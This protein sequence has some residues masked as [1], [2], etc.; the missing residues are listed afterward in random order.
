MTRRGRTS[1]RRARGRARPR[2]WRCVDAAS[3][4]L[5]GRR[6]LPAGAAR[7]GLPVPRRSSL[8]CTTTAASAPTGTRWSSRPR[9]IA[10]Q[11]RV[12]RS[13]RRRHRRRRRGAK[14]T[15]SPTILED[16]L[17]P[18]PLGVAAIH[19]ATAVPVL[20]DYRARPLGAADEH[21]RLPEAIQLVPGEVLLR[22]T[23]LPPAGG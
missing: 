19:H 5:I 20:L 2:P 21:P 15:A 12:A 18:R 11:W 17:L 22:G 16:P 1:R 14:V 9:P 23:R 3:D 4:R 7:P 10:L 8:R 13:Q 6:S